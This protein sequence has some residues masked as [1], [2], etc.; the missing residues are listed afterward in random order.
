MNNNLEEHKKLVSVVI[1]AYNAEHYLEETLKSVMQQDYR[2]LEIIVVDD[3]S[4]DQTSAIARKLAKEDNRIQYVYQENQG[5][6]AARNHGYRLSNGNYLGF[7]DA[8]DIWLPENITLKFA[9]IDKNKDV[10]L[11]HSDA[12]LIDEKGNS[13]HEVKAGQSGN[14]LDR[15][16]LWEGTCVH[17]PGSILVKREVIEKIGGFDTELST[18]ADQEFFMRVAASYKIDRLPQVTWHYRIHQQNMHSNI[19]LMERDT[20]LV[21]RKSREN[22][23]F[24]SNR[25][26][27]KCYS[28]MYLILSGSWYHNGKNT[29]RAILYGFKAVLTYPPALLKL[30]SKLRK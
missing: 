14:L 12:M 18:G 20:L 8:D 29:R 4:K 26:R 28:N 21:Y 22:H 19:T 7:L 9:L 23:F 24:K 11:V 17:S 1:P 3:G 16:L 6:S 27:R 30:L 13:L 15:M 10:G 25:F 2:H 5:V